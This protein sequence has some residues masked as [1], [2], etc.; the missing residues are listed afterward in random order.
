MFGSRLL[1]CIILLLVVNL[2]NSQIRLPRLISDG[3]VLQRETPLTMWGWASPGEK[4]EWQFGTFHQVTRADSAGNWTLEIPAQ[5][6]G[7]PVE[8]TISGKNQISLKDVYFGDVW[9]CSGQSNMELMMDRV[10]DKY[11]QVIADAN[12]PLIRQF[13]VSDEYDFTTERSDLDGGAWIQVN[14][15]T[16]TSFSAVAYFFA[17]ELFQKYHVPVGLINAALGGSPVQAW[18]SERSILAFPE[19][20]EEGLKYRNP[21]LIEQTE[22]TNREIMQNWF[23][24]LNRTDRGLAEHW[25][26]YSLPDNTW[27]T[28]MIPNYCTTEDSSIH[29]G[30]IWFRKH[31]NLPERLTGQSARLWLGRM[32][33]ADSVYLNGTL[34]GATGYQYPPRKYNIPQKIV[35]PGNNVISVRLISQSGRAGFVPDKPYALYF[36]QD[37]FDLEGPW[38]YQVGT[39]VEPMAATVAVRWKPMGLFNAM[40]APLT[41]Y[42]IKGVVWFQGESNTGDPGNY[43]PMLTA[44]IRDWRDRFGQENV[45]FIIIQLANF[46]ESADQPRES[47]W[48]ELREA[49]RKTAQLPGTGLV[50][51]IDLG[52]WNDIHPLNKKDV[53]YRAA[54]QAFRLAYGESGVATSPLP[55][56]ANCKGRNIFILFSETGSG[57]V[58][59][60]GRPLRSFAL[61]GSDGRWH[62]AQ[63]QIQGNRVKVWSREV[64]QPVRVRYAWADNPEDANL[65]NREG[66]PATPFELN[67]K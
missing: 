51:T 49:Q 12:N 43:Q 48:A 2:S 39:R 32:V 42:R 67:V 54:W 18:M 31:F 52:E 50:V 64:R 38:K 63:A 16:I 65:Y 6:A 35:K 4:V 25:E 20:Y 11:P 17:E 45:P 40:I 19:D 22:A 61:Q 24:E 37:T 53:G 5:P 36:K 7:G 9:L 47:N 21:R 59:R 55:V 66:L 60:D 41:R 3:M 46:L 13:T 62:W 14:P 8:I 27:K 57:L 33:D 29:T 44:M 26:Q 28:M 30:A 1:N 15:H 34:V 23:E 56:R 58:S 10:R